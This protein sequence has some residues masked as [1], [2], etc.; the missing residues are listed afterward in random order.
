MN[1]P[2]MISLDRMLKHWVAFSPVPAGGR[3]RLLRA[4]ASIKQVAAHEITWFDAHTLRHPTNQYYS[5]FS[6]AESNGFQSRLMVCI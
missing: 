5:V 1:S 4:A 3:Q 2:K 6:W